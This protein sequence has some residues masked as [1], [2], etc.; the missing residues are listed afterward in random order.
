MGTGV[1]VIVQITETFELVSR[2]WICIGEP[3]IILFL[4]DDHT[5]PKPHLSV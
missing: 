2:K 1:G 4:W 3:G 5:A